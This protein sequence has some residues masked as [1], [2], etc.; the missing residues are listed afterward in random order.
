MEKLTVTAMREDIMSWY[1]PFVRWLEARAYVLLKSK[2]QKIKDRQIEDHV[3]SKNLCGGPLDRYQRVGRIKYE[4][5]LWPVYCHR[6]PPLPHPNCGMEDV[7]RWVEVW[8]PECPQ[9]TCKHGSRLLP[10][11]EDDKYVLRCPVCAFSSGPYSREF[12]LARRAREFVRA[13]YRKR[14]ET[15]TLEPRQFIRKLLGYPD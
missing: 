5:I 7:L 4:N 10:E 1:D 11:R 6:D 13:N 9:K 12:P 14:V 3:A 2:A 8:D 15:E